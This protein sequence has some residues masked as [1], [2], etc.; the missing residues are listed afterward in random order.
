[1]RGEDPPRSARPPSQVQDSRK[2]W[3]DWRRWFVERTFAGLHNFRRLVVRWDRRLTMHTAF[4][5]V[6]LIVF[7]LWKLAL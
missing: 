2:L 1:V 4:F 7:L 5:H 6:A 3:P